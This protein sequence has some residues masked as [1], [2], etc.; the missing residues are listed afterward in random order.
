MDDPGLAAPVHHAALAGLARANRVSFAAASIWRPIAA[1]MRREPTRRWRL[2]DVASGAGDVPLGLA[3][4]ATRAGLPL[5]VV[6][7]DVSDVAVEHARRR[8]EASRILASFFTRDVLADGLPDDFDFVTCSL[9]LHHLDVD[10][11]VRLL[12]SIGGAAGTLGVVSDLRRTR[13]GY[14]M[15]YVATRALTRC[16]VVHVDGP[17]SVRG[18]FTIEEARR[19]ADQAG[20]ADR[21]E[22][23]PTWPQRFLMTIEGNSGR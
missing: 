16:R 21:V 23:R 10:D 20:L 18:A 19:L 12:R 17:L 14:A 5:A 2:L 6:G 4:R 9:F 15:A 8:A 22:I 3:R 11:A 13:L 1:R 7:C